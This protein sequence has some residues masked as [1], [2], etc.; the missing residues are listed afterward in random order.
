MSARP[1]RRTSLPIILAAKA[2]SY[3]MLLNAPVASG[4]CRSASMMW[5]SMV[6]MALVLTHSP[7]LGSLSGAGLRPA[8]A[9]LHPTGGPTPPP[10]SRLLAPPG[11]AA[12]LHAHHHR[13]VL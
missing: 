4:N 11:A 8:P 10:G 12:G 3:R 2:M 13:A 1:A 9:G 6:M 7:R 5:R